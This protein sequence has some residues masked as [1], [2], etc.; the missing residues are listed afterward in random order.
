MESNAMTCPGQRRSGSI[1][2]TPGASPGKDLHGRQA[3]AHGAAPSTPARPASGPEPRSGRTR[4]DRFFRFLPV[5]ALALLPGAFALF[6]PALAQAQ[7]VWSATLTVVNIGGIGIQFGCN[8]QSTA[9]AGKCNPAGALTDNDFSY[10]GDTFTITDLFLQTDPNSRL[11]FTVNKAIPASAENSLK[12]VVGNRKQEFR[13]SD[14]GIISAGGRKGARWDVAS[15]PGWTVGAMVPVSLVESPPEAPSSVHWSITG[16]AN[17]LHV[18][19]SP[20]SAAERYDLH[21]TSAPKTGNGAVSDNAAA[22]GTNPASGWVDARYTAAAGEDTSQ[23]VITRLVDGREYRVRLRGKNDAG[24]GPWAHDTGTAGRKTIVRTP[25]S[26]TTCRPPNAAEIRAYLAGG[27]GRKAA[28]TPCVPVGSCLTGLEIKGVKPDGT[29]TKAL[30]L[31]GTLANHVGLGGPGFYAIRVPVNLGVKKVAVTASWTSSGF[32]SLAAYTRGLTGGP[33]TTWVRPGAWPAS[34]TAV[35]LL[36]AP[37]NGA[38]RILLELGATGCAGV[39]GLSLHSYEIYA[40]HDN[41]ATTANDR[42]RTLQL[43]AGN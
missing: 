22:S 35:E 39:A 37:D 3:G 8:R 19:W 24:A 36:L 6:A 27:E 29:K 21:Y 28:D 38:T 31:S 32:S 2:T 12:L 23:H 40:Y 17:G 5:L 10:K 41:F 34:G 9:A 15:I 43:N 26:A 30:P 42:L 4:S 13:L 16:R 1:E 14:G 18:G 20:V 7:S 25:P 33:S 11:S